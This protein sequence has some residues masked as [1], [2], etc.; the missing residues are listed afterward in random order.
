[1]DSLFHRL[2]EV[3]VP[4]KTGELNDST[5]L[6]LPLEI[7]HLRSAEWVGVIVGPEE[8]GFIDD[9]LHRHTKTD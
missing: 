8:R 3:D 5:A 2:D 4:S 9:V 7:Q 1:M 6:N